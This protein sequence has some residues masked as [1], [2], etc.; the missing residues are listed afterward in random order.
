LE[1]IQIVASMNPSTTI[2]R[3]KISTRFTANVCVAYMDYPQNEEL[4]P[5]YAE[6]MKTILAHPNYGGGQMA[7]STKRLSQFIIDLYSN[8]KSKF[9]VDDHRHYLFTPRDITELV[10]SLLRYEIPEPQSLIEVL[11]YESSRVFKDRLVDRDSKKRFDNILYSLLKNHLK[12]SDRL[13]DTFFISK[14][15]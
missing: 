3:H 11:I 6:M 15:V 1:R 12:F 8:V 2:G 10:F 9:S 14:V 7:N 4:L 5:V 13:V